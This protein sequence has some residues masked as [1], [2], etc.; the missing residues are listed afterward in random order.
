VL[1]PVPGRLFRARIDWGVVA[2]ASFMTP[3]LLVSLG[4]AAFLWMIVGTGRLELPLT[5]IGAIAAW[6]IY[7]S[8]AWINGMKSR[9]NRDAMAFRKR[10]AAGRRFFLTELE[11]PDPILR[12]S[13]YPWLLSFGL[14]KQ[15]DLWSTRHSGPSTRSS[16]WDRSSTSG[17][18]SSPS[19]SSG[20]TAWTGGGGNRAGV[21]V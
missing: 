15:M 7:I 4:T 17:S 1:V 11:K 21:R 2:A 5:M 3:A 18:S 19:A 20:D 8:N 14:G 10:L 12:D 6:A 16:P 9:Q 13:W